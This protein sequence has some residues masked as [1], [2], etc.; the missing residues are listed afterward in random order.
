MAL[1]KPKLLFVGAFP[2]AGKQ[3]FGGNV[4]AC[5]TLLE[6]SFAQKFDLVLLDTTQASN[7]PPPFIVRLMYSVKRFFRFI[8]IFEKNRPDGVMVFTAAGASM[9]EKCTM[10]WYSR[11]RGVRS[12]NFPR[13]GRILEYARKRF[14]RMFLPFLFSGSTKVLCQ[15]PAWKKFARDILGR[16]EQDTPLI[17]NWTATGALLEIGKS[18]DLRE[19]SGGVKFLFV[20]WLEDHK[21][22]FELV[23][24][25]RSL[26][27]THE[28]SVNMVGSGH[29][30][31]QL[32]ERIDRYQ[33]GEKIF[34]HG[35]LGGDDLLKMYAENDVFVLPSWFEGLPNSLIEAM[36]AKMGIIV[37]DVGAIPDYLVHNQHGILLPPKEVATLADAMCFLLENPD[38]IKEISEN[39]YQ[40]AK[41]EW[42][43]DTA[44]EKFVE[45]FK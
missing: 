4:T 38:K 30:F 37:T 43:V 23:E 6:S 5:R 1:N 28:F 15:G 11:L 27:G 36:A 35:W 3:V 20:G 7:P 10:C 40:L 33:L 25:A 16:K 42:S 26:A 19:R 22:V 8:F 39:A 9:V 24:A 31:N 32:K 29:A 44:T 41:S 21:G 34:L 2:P 17:T 12:L 18:R 45:C 13:D 14:I